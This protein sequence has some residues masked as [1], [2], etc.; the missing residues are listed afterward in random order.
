MSN[1]F[2]KE[3]I[4]NISENKTDY[5]EAVKE[6]DFCGLRQGK[7]KCICGHILRKN[8][9]E[10]KNRYNNKVI[11]LGTTCIKKLH[12]D[13]GINIIK[14]YCKI[15]DKYVDSYSMQNDF[16]ILHEE[17]KEHKKNLQI[18]E[19]KERERVIYEE[20]QLSLNYY[21]RFCNNNVCTYVRNI[22]GFL[23]HHELTDLHIS[24]KNRVEEEMEYKITIIRNENKMKIIKNKEDEDERKKIINIYKIHNI[25]NYCDG[26]FEYCGHCEI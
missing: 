6:W 17:T 13:T 9:I 23:I 4:L 22:E 26:T 14:K 25:C 15:C 20:R 12:I 1:I 2:K 21:C 10:V 8:I 7:D 16:L 11:I 5:I 24:E 19:D 3:L 18:F